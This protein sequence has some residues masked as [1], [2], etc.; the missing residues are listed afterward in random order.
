MNNYQV[1]D[2]ETGEE[3]CGATV[4]TQEQREAYKKY[5]EQ[6]STIACCDAIHRN[7]RFIMYF[8][9]QDVDL[10]L[11]SLKPQTVAR[12]MYLATWL[13]Y[14]SD[15]L[16]DNS[17]KMTRSQM[18]NIMRLKPRTFKLFLKEVTEQGY[19]IKDGKTYRL[20]ANV[21]HR[22]KCKLDKSL[23]DKRY[24]RVYI[25]YVR[26]LYE[27]TPQNKHVNLGYIF[28]LIPF[29][30]R[31]YN[32]VC[33]NP[34][35]TNKD[36]IEPMTVGELCDAIGYDRSQASR[37]LDIYDNI[38]FTADGQNYYFCGYASRNR[39]QKDVDR[40]IYVNPLIFFAGNDRNKVDVLELMFV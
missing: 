10:S 16:F 31:E 25:K 22:G 18:E 20:N 34:L 17:E 7:R 36:L 5:K 15:Y 9:G 8:F 4:Y 23:M 14:N 3:I 19:L 1:I 33:H 6:E 2:L 27:M 35:E 12:L 38:T 39:K 30:N 24:V 37:L 13:G 28:Q 11:S 40:R 21:F 26:L 29:V 32:V